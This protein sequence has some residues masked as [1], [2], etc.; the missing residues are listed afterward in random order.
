MEKKD[1]FFM[2]CFFF[3]LFNIKMEREEKRRKLVNHLAFFNE[4]KLQQ[5]QK[6][7]LDKES[8]SMTENLAEKYNFF[9][10]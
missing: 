2:I 3:F 4:R 1:L 7:G 10:S 9:F 6:A 5:K 8:R